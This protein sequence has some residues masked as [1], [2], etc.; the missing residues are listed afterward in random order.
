MKYVSPVYEAEA[1]ATEDIMQL[2]AIDMA[3][4]LGITMSGDKG[5]ITEGVE[6]NL[7]NSNGE[8]IGQDP[9]AEGVDG[10]SISMNF[11]SLFG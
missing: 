9:T 5:K 4:R 10:V 2:S 1:I 8:I 6:I 3:N 11:G 7:T